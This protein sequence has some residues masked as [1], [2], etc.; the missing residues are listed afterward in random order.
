MFG[1]V[2]SHKMQYTMKI[3]KQKLDSLSK[4]LD[5]LQ[6]NLLHPVRESKHIVL[7]KIL[8]YMT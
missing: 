2:D 5:I 4:P 8:I 3:C 6:S 7:N 1:A